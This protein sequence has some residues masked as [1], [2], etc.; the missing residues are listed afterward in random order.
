MRICLFK[1]GECWVLV[2]VVEKQEARGF[3]CEGCCG[4]LDE[5]KAGRGIWLF[6]K[7]TGARV[8]AVRL[9]DIRGPSGARQVQRFAGLMKGE[10]VREDYE[11]NGN[12]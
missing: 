1:R 11:A 2:A 8:S 4:I 6:R 5:S 7:P 10:G 9:N 12:T 3:Q